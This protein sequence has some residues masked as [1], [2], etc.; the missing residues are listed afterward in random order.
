MVRSI[1]EATSPWN[2][3]TQP[4]ALKI[5]LEEACGTLKSNPAPIEKKTIK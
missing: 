4:L 3:K 1:N 2:G 5:R